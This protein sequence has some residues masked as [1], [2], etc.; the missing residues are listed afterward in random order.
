MKATATSRNSDYATPHMQSPDSQN[1]WGY[2]VTEPWP[3]AQKP[4]M[5]LGAQVG[6]LRSKKP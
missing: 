6:L 3:K 5:P 2:D 1:W 4:Y